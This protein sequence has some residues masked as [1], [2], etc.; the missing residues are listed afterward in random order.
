MTFSAGSP[1]RSAFGLRRPNAADDVFHA[2]FTEAPVAAVLVASDGHFAEV[3]RGLECLLG[4]SMEE[5]L[6]LTFADLTPPGEEPLTLE[7]LH[8]E[9]QERC[10]VRAGG[11][12]LWV[13]ISAGIIEDEHGRIRFHVVQ[14]ENIA[15]R[16]RTERKLR[17]LADHDALTWLLNRRSFLECVH[18][19]LDRVPGTGETGAMLLLDLDNF[20]RVNDTKGHAAGDAVL[21]TTAD[22]L[23]QRLRSTDVVSRLGGDEFAALL[24]KVTIAQAHDVA[25]DLAEMLR[26]V[27]IEVSI[28]VAGFDEH[29]ANEDDL[30][31]A[32][33]QAMYAAKMSRRDK[34]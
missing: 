13:A 5:L 8:R 21:R 14:I 12:P 10:I 3:N 6:G 34:R 27:S 29:T 17:R 28:G 16:K 32:A 18:D 11:E 2:A 22:V 33:D 20:K 1:L 15:D 4:Y 26:E 7:E 30:I 25:N 19:E 9:Q 23:R 31:A 24:S